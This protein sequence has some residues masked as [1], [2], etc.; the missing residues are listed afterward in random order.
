MTIFEIL[1][2]TKMAKLNHIRAEQ[3]QK[4]V[5]YRRR[6]QIKVLENSIS[7]KNISM[8]ICLS[9]T[10]EELGASKEGH[11]RNKKMYKNGK[12]ASH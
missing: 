5:L 9:P 2:Y 12:V 1:K 11:F 4:Y 6:P 7:Y 3:C 10:R 8:R